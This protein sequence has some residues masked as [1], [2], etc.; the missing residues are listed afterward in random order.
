MTDTPMMIARPTYRQPRLLALVVLG[1]AVGTTARWS[2]GQA[3]ATAPGHWPSVTFAINLIGS[4]LLGLLLETLVRSGPDAGWRRAVR[5][6]IGTGIL[7]GFTTYSTFV[8]EVDRLMATGHAW[9]GG[10]YAVL[11]IL[12]GVLAAVAGIG[13]ARTLPPVRLRS[14]TT[15]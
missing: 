3:F 1:G 8:V 15:P 7:G 14:R 5:V 11:S 12:I 4:F 2:L 6:G 13:L 10:A 9:T